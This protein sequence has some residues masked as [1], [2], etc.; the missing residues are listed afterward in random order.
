MTRAPQEGD[1]QDFRLKAGPG[2]IAWR[3]SSKAARRKLARTSKLSFI[4]EGSGPAGQTGL[5]A[6]DLGRIDDVV[7]GRKDLGVSYYLAAVID[8]AAQ[9]VTHVIRGN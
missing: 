9:E 5:M 8:D 2:P 3:L 4:E 6:I 1:V 7:L